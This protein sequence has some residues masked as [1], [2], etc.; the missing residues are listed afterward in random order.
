MSLESFAQDFVIWSI[1][2]LIVNALISFIPASI[3]DKKGH[4]LGAYWTISFFATFPIGLIIAIVVSDKNEVKVSRNNSTSN[5]AT[6]FDTS[7]QKEI[8]EYFAKKSI[9]P[10]SSER[11]VK[12]IEF[13]KYCH[14]I[15]VHILK[16]NLLYKDNFGQLYL[17][18]FL[19]NTSDKILNYINMEIECFDSVGDPV[20]DKDGLNVIKQS[21]LDMYVVPQSMFGK[22]TFIKLMDTEVRNIKINFVKALFDD[23]SVERYDDEHEYKEIPSQ[24]KISELPDKYYIVAKEVA[25]RLTDLCCFSVEG[26]VP[27]QNDDLTWNC[28]CGMVNSDEKVKC[29]LCG[30]DKQEQF[31]LLSLDYLDK[32]L[33][34][35]KAN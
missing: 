32:L 22:S 30:I 35:H 20:V 12:T 14:T 5:L 3:A 2:Y 27:Q 11:I 23:G 6:C 9:A 29:C 7:Y 18:L 21:Y 16:A 15:P 4:S 19:V 26:F 13:S 10:K 34:K 33:V 28:L 24:K 31:R 17:Q 8:N 1:V 25:S